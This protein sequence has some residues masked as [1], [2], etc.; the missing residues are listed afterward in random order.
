MRSEHPGYVLER[1]DDIIGS[2]I[3][4]YF[5]DFLVTGAHF[6]DL[7]VGEQFWC[8]FLIFGFVW[9]EIKFCSGNFAFVMLSL[10]CDWWDFQCG[11]GTQ[12]GISEWDYFGAMLYW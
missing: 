10:Y 5:D 2:L 4:T 8:I 1:R 12:L 6:G 3:L 7:F 9:W 11:C